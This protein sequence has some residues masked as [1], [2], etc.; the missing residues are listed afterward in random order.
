LTGF[1]SE[2]T[3]IGLVM[4][5]VPEPSTYALGVLGL[6]ALAMMRRRKA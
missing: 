4:Q 6:G 3:G 5:A 2:T 1:G